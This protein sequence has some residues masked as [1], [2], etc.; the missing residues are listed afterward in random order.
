[1]KHR[2]HC[3]SPLIE[4]DH[5]SER[6]IGCI[7]YNRWCRPGDNTLPMQPLRFQRDGFS[8]SARGASN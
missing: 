4:I 8:M 3:H 6:L 1:M 2:P 7:E 5:Y